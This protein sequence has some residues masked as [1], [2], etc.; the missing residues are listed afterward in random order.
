ML[1]AATL[2]I[3]AFLDAV[4]EWIGRIISWLTLLMVLTVVLVLVLRNWFDLSA[5]SLQES[6]TYMHACVFMLGAAYALKHNA[7]VRVDVFYQ[8]FSPKKKAIVNIL[9][10]LFLLLPVCLF[11]FIYC[12]DY[13]T[14]SWA[15]GEGSNQP[16]GIPF[17]YALKTLLLAMPITLILQGLSDSL[18][19]LSFLFGWIKA[20]EFLNSDDSGTQ[21]A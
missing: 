13:V 20:P 5:I 8:H 16:G 4:T 11:I 3:H 14:F 1:K 2:K 21:H 18:K 19:C 17:M 12:K 9:G 7:H 6:V 15:L 10:F